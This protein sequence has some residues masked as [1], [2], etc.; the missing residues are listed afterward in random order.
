VTCGEM[1]GIVASLTLA[2]RRHRRIS[3]ALKYLT[4]TNYSEVEYIL[5]NNI[6]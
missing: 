5:L 1:W 6:I 4:Q 3:L 2:T